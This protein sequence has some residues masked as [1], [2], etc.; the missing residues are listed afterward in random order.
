MKN[1]FIYIDGRGYQG[2]D[3][4]QTCPCDYGTTGFH[5]ENYNYKNILIFG[6]RARAIEG[7]INLKSHVDKI[8]SKIRDGK[9]KAKQIIINCQPDI[10]GTE[11]KQGIKK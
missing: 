9:I 2:E 3:P 10:D 1:Y 5:S 7:N 4:E 8:L 6:D 11:D